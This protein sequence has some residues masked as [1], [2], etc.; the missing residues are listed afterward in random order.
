MAVLES[1][2]PR[3]VKGA[4]AGAL[5]GLAGSFLMNQ[6][7]AALSG[8]AAR[9]ERVHAER[10]QAWW[11]RRVSEAH[12]PQSAQPEPHQE[13][14]EPVASG[15]P[16]PEDP[17]TLV[18][19]SKVSETLLH[20][21]LSDRGKRI[22]EPLVHYTYGTLMGAAYGAFAERQPRLT[23]GLGL[24]YGTVLWAIGDEIMVPLLRLSKAPQAYPLSVHAKALASHFVYGLT[25]EGIRRG[26]RR[27]MV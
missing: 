5:G 17:A 7:Q 14:V 9:R 16:P 6:F 25:L 20:H 1:S 2:A 21:P 8:L 24:S 4:L 11:A 13:E 10:E 18:L 26:L 22:A 15:G 3:T 12:R 19:A 23:A 27:L